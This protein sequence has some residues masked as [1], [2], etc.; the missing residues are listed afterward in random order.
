VPYIYEDRISKEDFLNGLTELY[1]MGREGRAQIGALGRAW[2][3]DRFSFDKFVQT[4][5]DL[6][7]QIHDEKGSWETRQ[8]YTPY[9]VKVF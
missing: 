9:E 6:F 3:E 4:W 8:G 1:E 7:T 5:D 2:A